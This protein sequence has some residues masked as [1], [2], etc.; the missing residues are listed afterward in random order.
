MRSDLLVRAA[1]LVRAQEPFALATVVRRQAA[2]SAQAGDGALITASGEFH[3]WLGGSCTQPTVIREALAALA[4]GKPRLIALSPDPGADR[5][6]GVLAFPMTC[7][8]GGSVEIYIEPVL[9]AARFIVF[10]VSPVARALSRLAAAMGYAVD[11]A[12]PAADRETFPEAERIWTDPATAPPSGVRPCVVVATMG[13]RDEEAVLAALA[14]DPAYLGV[15]ASGKRFGQI[16]DALRARGA[17]TERVEHIKN[18]AGLD[19]GA[20]TPEEIA[21]SILAEIVQVRRAQPRAAESGLLPQLVASREER[22]PVCGMMVD[23][24]TA[25]HRARGRR[26]HVRLL[27]R[28]VPR[29]VPGGAGPLWRPDRI[30]SRRVRPEIVSMQQAMESQGYIAEPSIATALFL[31]V[32]MRKPLLIEGDAGVGKTEIAK[33]L[34][35]LLDTELIRLQCYEGLDVQTALYEW[36]YPRQM[37]RLRMAEHEG[38]APERT[39]EVIYS[40]SYLLERPLLRAISRREGPA[41]LLVD[42]IDRA[43]DGFEAFLLEVLSDFQVTI[44]ELGTLR[45]EHVPFVILTSNRS[46][47]IGDALRRRCLYLYIEHPSFEKEVRILRARVPGVSERLAEQIGRFLQALRGRRLLKAPGV[48]ETI[49]WARA[50][51]RLHHDH[52]DTEAVAE[53]LGCLLKDHHDIVD[54]EAPQL[55]ALVDEARGASAAMG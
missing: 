14:T 50:L 20:Q 51:V 40:R 12:D 11:V 33:V 30:G 35:R 47:E 38:N 49:D 29:E 22:D 10:G 16:R 42:E 23:A 6:P 34:S 36:N 53:T 44:P 48:A 31:A 43:D 25:R 7:H 55:A 13:E 52:L 45:A 27:L 46:R 37:L 3:G 2:S 21:V 9:P 54:L 28:R 1:D 5:R 18:P 8:S 24:A 39:E 4:D 19:I 32:E 26:P 15:V 17:A 41:V